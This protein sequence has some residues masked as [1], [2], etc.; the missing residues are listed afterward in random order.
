MKYFLA[1]CL[2]IL[3]G[4]PVGAQQPTTPAAG[5]GSTVS[6]TVRDQ[7]SGTAVPY[8]TVNLLDAATKL[9]GGGISDEQGAFR[10]EGV[11][12]GELTLE[13]RFMGYQTVSQPLWVPAAG[14][15][16]D[17]GPVLALHLML[18]PV[19]VLRL[20]ESLRAGPQ[21]RS[22]AASPAT[23]CQRPRRP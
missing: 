9:V 20:A 7:A 14:G 11:L 13:V 4:Q 3:L 21:P 10:L 6:G 19:N 1:L 2:S 15:K 17:V 8:A 5:P 18:L 22:A 12:A 16:L 23:R